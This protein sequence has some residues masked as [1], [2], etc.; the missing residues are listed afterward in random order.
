MK[1]GDEIIAYKVVGKRNRNCSNV[2]LFFEK[3]E[4]EVPLSAVSIE[5]IKKYIDKHPRL[6]PVYTKGVKLKAITRTEGFFVFAT[7]DAAKTFIMNYDIIK[8][9]K[10]I[11]VKGIVKKA[12]PRVFSGCGDYPQRVGSKE[13]LSWRYPISGNIITLSELEVLT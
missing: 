7:E 2:I 1:K 5:N 4:R 10:I 6:F 3:I 8:E 12:K 13:E 11:K 9:S